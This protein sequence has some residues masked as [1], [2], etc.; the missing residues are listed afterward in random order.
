[1]L[2]Q[3]LRKIG[4]SDKEAKVYLAALELGK[5]TVQE[6]AVKANVNRTT[7]YVAIEGLTEKELMSEYL[8][9]HKRF[10]IAEDP[11]KLD[12]ILPDEFRIF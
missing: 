8:E 1:M 5:A 12:D 9:N 4:L 2:D 3:Q 11:S 7:T 6:I 10:F